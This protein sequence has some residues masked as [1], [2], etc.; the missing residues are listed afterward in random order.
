MPAASVKPAEIRGK[1]VFQEH[2]PF[3]RLGCFDAA[4]AGVQP[5]HGGRHAQERG[6][7]LQIERPHG[8]ASIGVRPHVVAAGL[9]LGLALDIVLQAFREIPRRVVVVRLKGV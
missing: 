4:L 1:V 2:P 5:E 8:L 3:A 7:F 6:G 9:G